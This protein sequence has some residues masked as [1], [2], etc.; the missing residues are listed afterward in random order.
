M[1]VYEVAKLKYG[2]AFQKPLW[3]SFAHFY[4]LDI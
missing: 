4:I 3:F 1:N 2:H